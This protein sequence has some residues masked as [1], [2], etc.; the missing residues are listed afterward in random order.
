MSNQILA[1]IRITS[2]VAT[3][4]PM[5][6]PI[7][8][9]CP[10]PVNR[11]QSTASM[12]PPNV[13]TVAVTYSCNRS[14]FIER[15]FKT[16]DRRELTESIQLGELSVDFWGYA[17]RSSPPLLPVRCNEDSESRRTV[18]RLHLRDRTNGTDG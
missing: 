6:S 8:L 17:I 13:T 5:I 2:K 9:A 7:V 14:S 10:S 4:A 16:A 15:S 12:I 11:P 18:R 3:L 1:R